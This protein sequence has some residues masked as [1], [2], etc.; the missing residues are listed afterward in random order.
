MSESIAGSYATLAGIEIVNNSRTFGYLK[1][2]LGPGSISVYGDCGGCPN[3]VE[4]LD[5]DDVTG[6]D[7]PSADNAPWYS[8]D[9]PESGDFLGFLMDEFEGLNSPFMR[10]FKETVGNGGVLSRSRLKSREMTWRG[11]LFGKTCCS[12]LYGLRWLS[13]TLS[14]LDSDCQD[15][16]GDDLELLVCCPDADESGV[17]AFRTIKAVGLTEG[18]TILNEHKTCTSD[19]SMGC[20]G[21]CILEIEFTLVAVQPWLYSP[22]IPVYNCV[23]MADGAQD[24]APDSDEECPPFNCSDSLFESAGPCQL[25][26]LPPTATYTNLCFDSVNPQINRANYL[27]VPRVLWNSL[28]EVVPVITISNR[29]PTT[30]PG[31]ALSFYS[32]PDGNPCGDL[33]L[34]TPECDNLCDDLMIAQIPG[35]SDFYIDGRTRKMS[36]I[37]QDTNTAFPGERHT[38]GPWSWPSFSQYGFCMRISFND[39]QEDN[40]CVSLSLVPR[41][42]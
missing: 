12:V 20:G 4:L 8:S 25:P 16:F 26:L 28:D 3:I 13:K 2:G 14:R 5:C 32:S 37:C 11:F 31:V 36:L 42:F 17:S 39:V 6:Y 27:S 19:C 29:G 21:S 10:P 15:C 23:P 35:G 38:N 9:N 1:A 24:A 7:R 22:E 18:P 33:L 34:N 41:T 40:L 30:V